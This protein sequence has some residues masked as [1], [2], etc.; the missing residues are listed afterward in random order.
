MWQGLEMMPAGYRL[1]KRCMRQA[2]DNK[3]IYLS[4][5]LMVDVLPRCI[6]EA[7]CKAA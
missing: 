7:V 5:C 2:A 6:D 1:T 4:I 3:E